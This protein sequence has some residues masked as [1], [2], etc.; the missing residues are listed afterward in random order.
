MDLR[1]VSDVCERIGGEKNK[2]CAFSRSD[3][4]EFFRAAEEFCWPESRR[5]QGGK[6]RE[7]GVHKQAELIMQAETREAK[8]VHGV[9][10]G[11]KRHSGTEQD[12]R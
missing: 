1:G 4:A 9:G 2:I 11:E 7:A 5:L 12:S 8:R 10:A 6:R 3:E